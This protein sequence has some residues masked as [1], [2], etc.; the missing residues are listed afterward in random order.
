MVSLIA[1]FIRIHHILNDAENSW[2]FSSFTAHPY[3]NELS[4]FLLKIQSFYVKKGI[5][6]VVFESNLLHIFIFDRF[7]L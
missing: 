5:M 3:T 4:I 1:V 2:H 7:F 6:L